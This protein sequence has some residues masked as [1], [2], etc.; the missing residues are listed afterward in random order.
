MREH[1]SSA[2]GS[3]LS[4]SD[5]E[6]RPRPWGGLASPLLSLGAPSLLLLVAGVVLPMVVIFVASIST[7]EEWGGVRW[8]SL[9][10]DAY[11]RLLFEQDFDG[12]WALN[13]GLAA[14]AARTLSLSLAATI[15]CLALGFPVALYIAMQP[16]RRRTWL[17]VFITVPF[18]TS[19][20]VRL[21]AW[22]LL[23]RSGGVVS[24]V[25]DRV[26]GTLVPTILY[27][28][29]ATVIGLVYA[30]MPF[31]VLPIF[32][33]LE[34]MDWN[35]VDAAFDLGATPWAVVTQIIAPSARHGI[36]SGCMLVLVP[37]L[38]AFLIPD[39]LGGA[40]SMMLGNLINLQFGDAHN[41]PLGASLSIAMYAL[42]LLCVL[43]KRLFT[44]A[45]SRGYH[46]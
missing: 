32:T 13:T 22:I 29:A 24:T 7:P 3:R 41:W 40:K 16:A 17:L 33:S 25:L 12:N 19:L 14:V 30:F 28:D 39:M 36:G 20:I 23:L 9:N 42:V 8:G 43:A 44:N 18:W 37:S 27:T 5:F 10:L 15:A 11:V 1:V 4:A 26:F 45:A 34:H 2:S 35:I 31:M 6:L 38:G 46:A 21:Y